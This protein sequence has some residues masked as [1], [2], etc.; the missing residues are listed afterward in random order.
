VPALAVADVLAALGRPAA[1]R[2]AQLADHDLA[3]EEV[4]PLTDQRR[5]PAVRAARPAGLQRA[6]ALAQEGALEIGFGDAENGSEHANGFAAR[7]NG[8]ARR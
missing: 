5:A 4:D 7:P 6:D 2:A 3:V 1:P 8:P